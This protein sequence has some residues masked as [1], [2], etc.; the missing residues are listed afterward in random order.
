MQVL[1]AFQNKCGRYWPEEGSS[2]DYGRI[3]VR[4]I[5]ESSNNDYILREFLVVNDNKDNQSER[6]IFH[7]HFTV[8]STVCCILNINILLQYEATSIKI[9]CIFYILST[10]C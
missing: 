3:T 7:Y 5:S 8:S 1:L 9:T 4:N 2:K 6:K 10:L